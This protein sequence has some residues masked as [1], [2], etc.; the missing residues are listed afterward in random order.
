MAKPGFDLKKMALASLLVIGMGLVLVI[1]SVLLR[2]LSMVIT[3]PA[4]ANVIDMVGMAYTVLLLP[5]FFLLFF[6]AGFRA[7]SAYG[8]DAVGAGIVAAFS[9]FVCACAHLAL[10]M[11][12]TLVVVAKPLG[13]SGFGTLESSLAASLFGSMIGM[14]GVG[15]TAVCG[16]GVIV[17]GV[18]MNFVV[19]GFGG[20]FALRK[21]TSS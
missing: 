17:M 21:S 10:N 11:V 14:T 8:F 1:L 16:A 6:W 20:L 18:L 2:L 19:G 13:G 9:Y 15:L 3:D 7:A 12:L 5:V 4:M